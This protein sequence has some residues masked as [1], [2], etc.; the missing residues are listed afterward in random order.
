MLKVVG[1]VSVCG[2]K[3]FG[4]CFMRLGRYLADATLVVGHIGSGQV[5][6]GRLNYPRLCEYSCPEGI[7]LP[8]RTVHT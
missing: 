1:E 3:L 4:S 2:I 8:G 5:R 7:A 6:S